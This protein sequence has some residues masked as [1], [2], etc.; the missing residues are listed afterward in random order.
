MF[1]YS[2]S[3]L[4]VASDLVLPGVIARED[5]C[6]PAEITIAEGPVPESLPA[7]TSRG[8]N[9]EIAGDRL[10]IRIPDIITMLLQ[11]GNRIT[12]RLAPGRSPR[13]GAIFVSGTGFG[14]LMHQRGLCVLHASAVRVG[15]RAA[16]FC[17]RSGAGKSTIAAALGQAGHAFV[18][19]D[20]CAI[21]GI[22]EGAPLVHADG[23]AMK[24]WQQAIDRLA[25]S[26]QPEQAVREGLSK[27][28]VP[29]PLAAIEP[30]PLVAVYL[31]T[32]AK[33][34]DGLSIARCS[35]ADAAQAI[36]ANAYRPPVIKKMGQEGLYLQAAAAIYHS[37][38]VYRLV[39]PLGF[40]AIPA[41]I[42][43]L[44][45]HWRALEEEPR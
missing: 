36:R 23:R 22:A 2:I 25:P 18:A 34:T 26:Q 9:W 12:Y 37:V 40:D 10:L 24:L 1:G 28:Y 17:G 14:L 5:D 6:I 13:D 16:L 31:L 29:V 3:G 7:P 44:E 43:G 8:P 32:D 4:H 45:E 21:S 35:L 30:L 42:A 20:Q 39:R 19:D 38:G 27:Y 41:I 11:G 15:G 33:G